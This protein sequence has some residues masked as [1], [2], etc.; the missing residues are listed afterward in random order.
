MHLQD[1]SFQVFGDGI[2]SRSIADAN[3]YWGSSE[4]IM[5]LELAQTFIFLLTPFFFML[6]LVETTDDDDDQDGGGMGMM[7]PAYNPS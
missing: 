7:V 1:R 4:R 3:S 6:L 5:N 2:C